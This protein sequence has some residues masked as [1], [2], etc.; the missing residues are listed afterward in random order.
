MKKIYLIVL[1]AILSSLAFSQSKL[2]YLKNNQLLVNDKPFLMIGGELHNSSAS[3]IGYMESIWPK[4]KSLNLN[5]VLAAVTWDQFEPKEGKFDFALIDYLIE[6]AEKNKIKLVVIWFG[7]WKNGQSSYIPLWV[8]TDTKRFPR[9]QTVDG[10]QLETLSVFSDESRDADAR[11]FTSLMKRIGEKDSNQTVIMVQPENEVGIF[12]DIDYRSEVLKKYESQ[13]PKSLTDYLKTNRKTLKDEVRSIWEKAG[14]KT[15]GTWK[16]IF[17][18]NPQSKE[19][20]MAW[21]YA[22]Y[23]NHIAESGRKKHNLPMFVNAW[24]VQKPDDLPGVY[25]NGG[26]VSR[27]MDIYKAA[28]PSIDIMCPDIYLPNYKEIYTQ[29]YRKSDNPLLVPES[30]LDAARAFFA[31]AEFDAICFSPFGI[32]DAAGDVL[33]S[34]SYGLL[35]E[36]MPIITK[37][38]GTGKM[39]GIH[40]TSDHQDEV[41]NISGYEINLKIQDPQKPAFG[42]IVNTIENEFIVVG[43]NFKA[44]FQKKVGNQIS[45]IGKVIEGRFVNGQWVD[46]RW[47]NGD[48]TYHNELLRAL[49]REVKMESR[50]KAKEPDLKVNAGDQFVYSPSHTESMVTPGIY[51]VTLYQ[52]SK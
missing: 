32:E 22:K 35:G 36:L 31:F 12:Q 8:K 46:E 4:L 7:S 51:K 13:V 19:F 11:A 30:S 52:R 1:L 23:I 10:R 26:P 39:R 15:T 29:Y 38:Q 41:L 28:A 50:N 45:Y 16:E 27:V 3:S 9:A 24:I 44:T 37:Y 47:L 49:G 34:Y 43:M 2:P 14:S 17:G 6:N 40:L 33:F 5:T 48:E 21:H 25:P 20:F 18:A 42:L